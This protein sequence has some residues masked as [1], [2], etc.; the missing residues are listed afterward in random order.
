MLPEVRERIEQEYAD[1]YDAVDL[2]SLKG[3]RIGVPQVLTKIQIL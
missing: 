3:I 2:D 1:Y